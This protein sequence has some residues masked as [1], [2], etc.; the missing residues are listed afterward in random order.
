[1]S[2]DLTR[3]SIWGN[4]WANPSANFCTVSLLVSAHSWKWAIMSEITGMRLGQLIGKGPR[5]TFILAKLS[6]KISAFALAVLW[7]RLLGWYNA[8]RSCTSLLIQ[9][10]HHAT[11]RLPNSAIEAR[12]LS[13]GSGS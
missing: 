12:S 10:F 3:S 4:F 6:P 8:M 7:K 1:M 13:W 11:T 9:Q 5:V 2:A